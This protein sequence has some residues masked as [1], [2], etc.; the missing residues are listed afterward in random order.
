MRLW[1]RVCKTDPATTKAV[2]YGTRQFTAIDAYAQ[3][4]RAT[5]IWGPIGVGWGFTYKLNWMDTAVAAEVR[6]WYAH[7]DVHA[8]VNACGCKS[9][10]IGKDKKYDDDAPKKAVTDGLTKAMS[11]LGFNADVFLGKFDDNKYV[12][13]MTE[14]F[15]GS[16]GSPAKNDKKVNNKAI[17]WQALCKRCKEVGLDPLPDNKTLAGVKN[18]MIDTKSGNTIAAANKWDEPSMTMANESTGWLALEFI[19]ENWPVDQ[20][21]AQ[22]KGK[23]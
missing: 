13:Q 21:V 6:L 20:T 16:N 14:E 8:E 23:A 10:Y 17:F 9:L 18:L 12:Q 3:I 5:E 15:A 7:E 4:Q 2:S 19:M 11:Y 1:N 22:L